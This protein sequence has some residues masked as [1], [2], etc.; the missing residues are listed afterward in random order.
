MFLR[1]RR[2]LWG[3]PEPA[4]SREQ[5]I[6]LAREECGRAGYPWEEPIRTVEHPRYYGIVTR[7]GWKGGN[8]CIHVDTQTGEAH[9]AGIVER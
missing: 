9:I 5:A 6:A 3:I 8:V 1:L 2:R 4:I 7:I